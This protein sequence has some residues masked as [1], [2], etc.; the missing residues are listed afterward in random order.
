MFRWLEQLR[1]A[2]RELII[3]ADCPAWYRAYTIWDTSIEVFVVPKG[4]LMQPYIKS[5]FLIASVLG[6]C[7][8]SVTLQWPQGMTCWDFF[9]QF[10][11]TLAIPPACLIV[12][13][14]IANLNTTAQT[15]GVFF[16]ALFGSAWIGLTGFLVW[17][18]FN[19][20][21]LF[22]ELLRVIVR[23]RRG[24]VLEV[25]DSLRFGPREI[26]ELN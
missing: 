20:T 8:R 15:V 3:P 25:Y 23:Y 21:P 1:Q 14:D 18:W 10:L 11:L 26:L 12:S 9:L 6:F 19:Q 13:R 22:D 24:E 2:T 16:L 7:K 17:Y 5:I 4:P